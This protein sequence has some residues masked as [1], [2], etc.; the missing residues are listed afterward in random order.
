M[1]TFT[2]R[3][4]RLEDIPGVDDLEA[5]VQPYRPE[6]EF[7]VQAMHRRAENAEKSGDIRWAP[8]PESASTAVS[9]ESDP[10]RGLDCLWIATDLENNKNLIAGL[11]GIETFRPGAIIGIEHPLAVEWQKVQRIA[12]LRLVRVA[13]ECRRNGIAMR[14]CQ[15]AIDWAREQGYDTLIVNTTTPQRPARSLYQKLGFGEKGI[16][17]IG[18][19]ELVWMELKL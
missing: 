7:E 13:P 6:D 18:K 3:E 16:S 9:K 11:A 17:F 10:F 15:R 12:E 14:I 2:V 19:Y 4:A 1:E 5:R 8:I